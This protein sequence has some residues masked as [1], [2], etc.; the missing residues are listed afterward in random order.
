MNS[1]A[2]SYRELCAV[3]A[4]ATQ[5]AADVLTFDRS[6]LRRVKSEEG[7]D[8]KATGDER[9][10]RSLL[11]ALEP[12]GFPILSEEDEG[13]ST[14]SLTEPCWIIDPLDGT[15]NYTRG[16]DMYAVSV[17][18]WDAGKPQFGIVKDIP[19]GHLYKGIIDERATCDDG[20]VKVSRVA[21]VSSAAVATGFPSGRDFGAASLESFLRSVQRFKKV[22]MLGSAALSL[23]HVASG[24][25]D[26]YF[27][28]DIWLWDVAAGL[29]L[30][31]AAGGTVKTSAV[32]D[33]WKVDVV[34]W[35]GQFEPGVT[36]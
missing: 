15:F 14:V 18:F 21:D 23:A 30:V 32:K 28:E 35:N 13:A 25:F 26:V 7:K 9:A 36:E 5:E 17:A 31:Q 33:D 16:F 22:R 1:H 29:A 20:R 4:R 8:V 12:T 11:G 19:N 10:H 6:E 27:E 34:A 24:H 3:A 2:D